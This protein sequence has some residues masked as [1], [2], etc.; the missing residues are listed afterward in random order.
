MSGASPALGESRLWRVSEWLAASLEMRCP[1]WGCGFE[2]HA[3]RFK[4]RIRPFWS[5]VLRGLD[6]Q[7]VANIFPLTSRARCRLSHCDEGAPQCGQ[8]SARRDIICPQSGHVVRFG[9][10]GRR[11]AANNTAIM[12]II[13]GT[14]MIANMATTIKISIGP[15]L[16]KAFIFVLPL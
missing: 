13:A 11:R 3:L 9:L 5:L 6:R 15:G 16:M 4:L 7:L 14:K 1:V 2:S 8:A 12:T 10:L